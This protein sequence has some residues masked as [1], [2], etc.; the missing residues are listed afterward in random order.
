MRKWMADRLKR[1]KKTAEPAS[2]EP[3]ATPLQPAYFDAPANA[4]SAAEPEQP[5]KDD[6]PY[7][8]EMAEPQTSGAESAEPQANPQRVQGDRGPNRGNAQRGRRRRGGRGR[9]RSAVP[10]TP[11]E[12][13]QASAEPSVPVVR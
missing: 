7:V 9:G 6:G 1:R 13:A 8:P 5:A 11:R 12:G 3:K 10:G 2:S 4:P